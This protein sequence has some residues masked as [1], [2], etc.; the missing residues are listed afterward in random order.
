MSNTEFLDLS[1]VDLDD[2]F[3]P[4][5]LEAGSE[6]ELV[7]TSMLID[8]NKNGDRYMMPFF[9][10]VGQPTVKDITDYMELP[11]EGMAPKDKNNA[12]LKIRDFG[13]AF[14]I[15]F[16][17]SLDIKNDVVGKTGY[18]ILGVGKDRDK[19]EANSIRKYSA[20]A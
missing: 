10:V 16:A 12:K 9:D 18:A 11:H 8:T 1:S 20:G 17:S 2:T 3:E 14:G 7:I 13:V 6:V 15:D 4:E 5:V 19:N